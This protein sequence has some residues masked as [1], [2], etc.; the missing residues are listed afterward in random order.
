MEQ[1]H[2]IDE[3][4]RVA[5]VYHQVRFELYSNDTILFQLEPTKLRKRIVQVFG[6]KHQRKIGTCARVNQYP[7]SKRIYF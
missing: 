5:L 6:K 4:Q 7:E 1:R 2:I 3:F